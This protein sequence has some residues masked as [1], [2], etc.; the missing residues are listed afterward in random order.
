VQ[1]GDKTV[2]LIEVGPAHTRG[3]VIV[4][5][6]SDGVVFTGDILFID[7]TPIIW[8]GPVE[9]WLRACDRILA[10]DCGVIVPGHGPLTDARGVHAVRDYLVYVR[11]QARARYEAGL[12]VADAARDIARELAGS[13]FGRWLDAERVVV[14]V[15]TLYRELSGGTDGQTNL[16]ELFDLMA[17]LAR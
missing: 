2:H 15:N 11:D 9:S 5:V 17:E 3:D 6:P 12:S 13:P 16:V 10:L 7:D 4:H 8:Q 1:V 14:N